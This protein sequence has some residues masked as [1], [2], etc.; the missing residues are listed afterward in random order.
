MSPNWFQTH[1]LTNESSDQFCATIQCYKYGPDDEK[2]SPFFNY[3]DG[4]NV[5]EFLPNSDFDFN[6]LR[7]ELLKE[8]NTDHRTAKAS[9]GFKGV[10]APGPRTRIR[11][12]LAAAQR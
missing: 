8:Y 2:Q 5:Q 1:K 12:T 7:D 6:K 9:K 10:K 4:E 11:K 3:L